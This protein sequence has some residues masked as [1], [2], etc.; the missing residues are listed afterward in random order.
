MRQ[1]ASEVGVQAGA[2]YNYTPDKQS[3]LFDLMQTHMQELLAAHSDDHTQ[4][5]LDRLTQFV[6]F[7]IEFHKD[8]PDEVFIAYMELRN[9]TADNFSHVEALRRA[10]ETRV[11]DILKAGV[12]SRDFTVQD[13][14]IAT[15]AII[16]M[17]NGVNLWFREDG[18]LTFEAVQ[19]RHLEMVLGA[20]G[21]KA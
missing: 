11:E 1:I 6:R 21:A 18:A 2:L 17:L 19:Q 7:H 20:V 5:P 9:L 3:L 14:R 15:R 8:R 10:Y 12:S 4:E 16:A 13:T